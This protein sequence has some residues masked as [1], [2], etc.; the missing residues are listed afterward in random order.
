MCECVH[1]YIY[2]NGVSTRSIIALWASPQLTSVHTKSKK[3]EIWNWNQTFCIYMLK[4]FSSKY[5]KPWETRW[6]WQKRSL[7][8]FCIFLFFFGCSMAFHFR[9][10]NYMKY[11]LLCFS[12]FCQNTEHDDVTSPALNSQVNIKENWND[13]HDPG[14]PYDRFT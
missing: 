4:N 13:L 8:I 10:K 3:R 7:L 6:V 9:E 5:K 2:R 12:G 11:T 14:T 1:I